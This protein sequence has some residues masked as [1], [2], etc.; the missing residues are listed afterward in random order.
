MNRPR[1]PGENCNCFLIGICHRLLGTLRKGVY[2]SPLNSQTGKDI[3][4]M[5]V[6]MAGMYP[7]HIRDMHSLSLS[8]WSRTRHTRSFP[9]LFPSLLSHPLTC[10]GKTPIH[11]H[12]PVEVMMGRTLNVPAAADK[13]VAKFT[14]KVCERGFQID[15]DSREKKS[16]RDRSR[17]ITDEREKERDRCGQALDCGLCL[18]RSCVSNQKVQLIL[19]LSPLDSLTSL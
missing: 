8:N 5:F 19:L 9:R 4:E 6:S 2:L 10:A 16:E 18:F 12:V 1:W 15:L 14:F 17:G 7:S 11:E 13:V 3:Q